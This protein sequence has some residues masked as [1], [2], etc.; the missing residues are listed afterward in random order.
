AIAIAVLALG[1]AHAVRT[2]DDLHGVVGLM[3]WATAPTLALATL[4]YS[5]GIRSHLL[6][7][8][9]F[10][11]HSVKLEAPRVW[12]VML[13]APPGRPFRFMPGQFQFLRLL[14]SEVPAEEHPFTIASSPTRADRLGLTIKACGD[15][16]TL[17]DRIRPGDRATVQGPFGRF[18]HDLHLDENHL[19]FVAGGVGITPFMS[20]LR[21]M[22]D[23]REPR[24]VTLVYAS[25]TL[26]DILFMPE[27]IAMESGQYPAL[28]VIYV[29]SKP[30]PWWTG[31]TRR[32]DAR[33]LDEWCGGL[34]DKAFYL[35][36]PPS[37]NVALVRGLRH[38]QVSQRRIHCDY[39]SL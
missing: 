2:G 29:L 9:T 19:V 20:M 15:F 37:M 31:E 3:L 35:C 32:V 8:R 21:A 38:R 11:V 1:C 23:R 14:D 7:R 22:H 30:P 13:D 25:R 34:K 5:R 12:T 39:F 33:R 28:K 6:A 26:D 18:S 17:I 27:L 24:R 16:T 4:L 36:C 10:R